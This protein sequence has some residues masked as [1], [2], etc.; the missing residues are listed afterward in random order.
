MMERAKASSYAAN[1]YVQANPC[2]TAGPGAV[3][4]AVIGLPLC[5]R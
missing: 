4:G 1:E 2:Q 3:I 5:H